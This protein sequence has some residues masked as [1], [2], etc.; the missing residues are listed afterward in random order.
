MFNEHLQ[1]NFEN[2]LFK[3]H[4]D[5]MEILHIGKGIATVETT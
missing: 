4:N 5:L 2:N 1:Q 3:T